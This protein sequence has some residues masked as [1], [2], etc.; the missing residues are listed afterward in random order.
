MRDHVEPADSSAADP[1][2]SMVLSPDALDLALMAFDVE[3]EN[4]IGAEAN[5]GAH[6]K[7]CSPFCDAA[8]SQQG[9][10]GAPPVSPTKATC[11]AR[12]SSINR[13]GVSVSF[14][15]VNTLASAKCDQ[16]PQK[17]QVSRACP[18]ARPCSSHGHK[19]S[20]RR[21][22]IRWP[23]A[24]EKRQGLGAGGKGEISNAFPP[25]LPDNDSDCGP[26]VNSTSIKQLAAAKQSPSH[27]LPDRA[28]HRP[29][30]VDS[31]NAQSRWARQRAA[32]RDAAVIASSV[33]KEAEALAEANR[34]AATSTAAAA[35][36]AASSDTT[37]GSTTA[38]GVAARGVA[39]VG[40]KRA[41]SFA[42]ELAGSLAVENAASDDD[43]ECSRR[44][45]S[46]KQGLGGEGGNGVDGEDGAQND[47]D[48]LARASEL[49][50]SVAGQLRSVNE[51]LKR[52]SYFYI[53]TSWSAKQLPCPPTAWKGKSVG[54]GAVGGSSA[55]AGGVGGGGVVVEIDSSSP[56]APRHRPAASFRNIAVRL[57][58]RQW[59]SAGPQNQ[60]VGVYSIPG[61]KVNAIADCTIFFESNRVGV[62]G[63]QAAG[64][65]VVLR[66]V[67]P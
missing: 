17:N 37:C 30:L 7:N 20:P 6:G 55:A 66:A 15:R 43:R 64:C 9:Y 2:Q 8:I 57:T 49:H 58:G 4:S 34:T 23:P 62:Q 53:D 21:N 52:K 39:P 36:T 11:T 18:G 31:A 33:R 51:L 29:S 54:N 50:S 12:D 38:K 48:L 56:L 19:S 35:S 40:E 46:L 28:L 63:T 5:D 44:T 22:P 16:V 3:E 32:T 13:A 14:Q 24:T 60:K 47:D 61:E 1:L 25:R 41:V 59:A 27:R 67:P 26:E 45:D 65:P 42:A 10:A